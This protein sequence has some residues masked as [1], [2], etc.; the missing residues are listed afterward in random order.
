MTANAPYRGRVENIDPGYRA[1]AVTP[2]NTTEVNA[3]GLYVGTGGNLVI[4]TFEGNDVTFKNV[5]SGSWLPIFAWKVKT[6]TTASDIVALDV[7]Q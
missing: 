1:T 6:S 5:A 4:T 2:S 7:T 3:R